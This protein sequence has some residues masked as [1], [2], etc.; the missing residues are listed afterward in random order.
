MDEGTPLEPKRGFVVA[1]DG[2]A[3]AGKSTLA[4]ALAELLGLPYVNTGLMY[5][6]VTFLALERGVEPGAGGPL[7]SLAREL[8]FGLDGSTPPMLSI[9]GLPDVANLRSDEVE[10]R[11][12]RVSGHPEVRTVLRATQRALGVGGCVMEGRD[13][14]TVVFPDADVK[15]FLSAAPDVRAGRRRLE[16]GGGHEVDEAVAA[17]DALDTRTNPLEAASDAVVLDT[18][19]LD[20][21]EMLA[22]AV[23]LVDATR[24]HPARRP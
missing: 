13:I 5:R 16:R 9:D 23:R 21:D 12:S 7:A 1:I 10:A 15:V 11:V 18:T 6:A 8:R 4:R 3:G 2:P 17:R 24:P 19:R 22:E 20:R 14:G